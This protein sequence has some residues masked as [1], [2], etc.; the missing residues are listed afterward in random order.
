MGRAQSTTQEHIT[1]LLKAG[2]IVRLPV[3]FDLEVTPA[4]AAELVQ[5]Q[6]LGQ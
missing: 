6:A 2:L 4:G 1:L 5:A 3:G